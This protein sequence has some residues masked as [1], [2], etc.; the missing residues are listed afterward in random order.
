M[1]VPKSLICDSVID[2]AASCCVTDDSVMFASGTFV[3]VTAAVRSLISAPAGGIAAHVPS[4]R[5]YVELLALVPLFTIVFVAITAF[6][7]F[8]QWRGDIEAFVFSSFVPAFGDQVR[9]YLV[10]FSDKARGLQTAGM[11]V[12]LVTALAMMST[13]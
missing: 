4:P 10:E 7:A 9:G 6:P 2:R 13:I 5:Q 1:Y 12:L 8:Q 11:I 3:H